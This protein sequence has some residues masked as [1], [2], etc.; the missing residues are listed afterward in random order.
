MHV[1]SFLPGY[2][3]QNKGT[4]QKQGQRHSLKLG[5]PLCKDGQPQTK[6]SFTQAALSKVPRHHHDYSVLSEQNDEDSSQRDNIKSLKLFNKKHTLFNR[7]KDD[8]LDP[9]DREDNE[10]QDTVPGLGDDQLKMP[11]QS[12]LL[13]F[14]QLKDKCGKF[15]PKRLSSLHSISRHAEFSLSFIGAADP[16]KWTSS[17]QSCKSESEHETSSKKM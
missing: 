12:D 14:Q 8:D 17:M 10:Y 1:Q 15:L 7:L 5:S 16:L 2:I 9:F 13:S 3:E 4:L 6:Q 11:S